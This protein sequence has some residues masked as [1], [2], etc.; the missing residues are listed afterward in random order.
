M[1]AKDTQAC[2]VDCPPLSRSDLLSRFYLHTGVVG[3]DLWRYL[4]LPFLTA[5]L[6]SAYPIWRWMQGQGVRA[7]PETALLAGSIA[8]A[9]VVGI[10]MA[11]DEEESSTR[12]FLDQLPARGYRH[13]LAK[14][15]S[16]ALLVVC[17]TLCAWLLLDLT[18]G[19]PRSLTQ[20]LVHP[21]EYNLDIKRLTPTQ[22]AW[23]TL[24]L[25]LSQ[26]LA[27]LG[28]GALARNLTLAVSVGILGQ[29]AAYGLLL[30]LAEGVYGSNVETN[31]LFLLG[32]GVVISL[33]G[34][35]ALL[36]AYRYPRQGSP[37]LAWPKWSTAR[38]TRIS[39]H[40][41][42]VW[43]R[44]VPAWHPLRSYLWI[45]APLVF[46]SYPFFT[47]LEETRGKEDELW[48]LQTLILLAVAG[49]LFGSLLFTTSEH[50]ATRFQGYALP[51][52]RERILG[53]KLLML[54]EDMAV[55]WLMIVGGVLLA[56]SVSLSLGSSWLSTVL[57]YGWQE[58]R[59]DGALLVFVPELF[60]FSLVLSL[61]VS[62][63][64]LF[65]RMR[66]IAMVLGSGLCAIWFYVAAASILT[67]P[68]LP[69]RGLTDLVIKMLWT[70]VVGLGLP[71]LALFLS[72]CRS[73][74]LESSPTRRG[75]A[76]LALA[77]FLLVWGTFLLTLSPMDLFRILFS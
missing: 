45:A 1:S 39:E 6:T 13:A 19:M 34:L 18:V 37:V 48:I 77:A 31:V 62:L 17:G 60:V 3:K 47:W 63:F 66:L 35:W 55:L 8:T 72:F 73:P 64:T 5:L 52:R 40:R 65:L 2:E 24:L 68:D 44:W 75:L 32:Y 59:H 20:N 26:L 12:R 33:L 53:R 70:A 61:L 21:L 15:A 49:N 51:L 30:T 29:L 16:G 28:A 46:L 56:A 58:I 36:A 57:I 14:L 76:G 9:F 71:L 10:A 74:L 22:V 67:G 54:A 42:A 4:P 7:K 38:S 11:D 50:D 27:G 69:G 41:S 25:P 43:S 23:I